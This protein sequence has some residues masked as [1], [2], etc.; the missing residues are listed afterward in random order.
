MHEPR[1]VMP[2]ALV[3]ANG[4]SV[5]GAALFSRV[6]MLEKLSERKPAIHDNNKYPLNRAREHIMELLKALKPLLD[7]TKKREITVM[8]AKFDRAMKQ[9]NCTDGLRRRLM[10]LEDIYSMMAKTGRTDLCGK[11]AQI[12]LHALL[13]SEALVL[14]KMGTS[15]IRLFIETKSAKYWELAEEN[16]AG[17][18]RRWEALGSRNAD[19]AKALYWLAFI[20]YFNGNSESAIVLAGKCCKLAKDSPALWQLYQRALALA[21]DAKI[22]L[23]HD[24]LSV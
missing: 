10:A 20:K 2:V 12:V 24:R 22:E 5:S 9:E 3:L 23:A 17:A 13:Q 16:L 19:F 15:Q 18:A 21:S 4:T 7:D 8:Q 1:E 14:K 6:K 11:E